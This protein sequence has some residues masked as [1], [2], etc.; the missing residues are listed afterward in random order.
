MTLLIPISALLVLALGQGW[1]KSSPC[2]AH[3]AGTS[4]LLGI[5]SPGHGRDT[6]PKVSKCLDLESTRC[7]FSLRPLATASHV[8]R[9]KVKA[10]GNN[11]PDVT[12]VWI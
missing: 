2:V 6:T 8:A 9:P 7:H 4:G 3:S 12:V 11:S 10:W 1:S 5:C